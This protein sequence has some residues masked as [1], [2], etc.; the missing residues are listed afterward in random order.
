MIQ[1]LAISIILLFATCSGAASAGSFQ[2]NGLSQRFDAAR[3]AYSNGDYATAIAKFQ[4]LLQESLATPYA[5]RARYY[6]GRSYYWAKRYP[7][8]I[9]TYQQ[10]KDGDVASLLAH[11]ELCKTHLAAKERAKA[12]EQYRWL[13]EEALL[14]THAQFNSNDTFAP[15]PSHLPP[16]QAQE[17]WLKY[18]RELASSMVAELANNFW[19]EEEAAKVKAALKAADPPVQNVLEMGK[20]GAGRPTLTHKVKPLYTE[21]ARLSLTQGIVVLNVVFSVEGEIRNIKVVRGLEDG[22]TE[23]AIEAARKIRFQPATKDGAP[24]SVRGHLEFLF[25]PY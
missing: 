16:A 15:S 7:E 5:V 12:E 14:A 6:L 8:A 11:Y 24:V 17:S 3:Q 9:T 21:L 1:P 4:E 23:K 13:K 20:N 2:D 19:T 18:Y 10:L 25:N 22:L